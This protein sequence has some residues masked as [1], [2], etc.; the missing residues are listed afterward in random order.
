M[1]VAKLVK[2]PAPK[3]K[4][5]TA[6]KPASKDALP[7]ITIKPRAATDAHDE[8]DFLSPPPPVAEPSSGK[9]TAAPK[10]KEKKPRAKKDGTSSSKKDGT[11]VMSSAKKGKAPAPD[12]PQP[13]VFK[14]R[15]F[16]DDSD[17]NIVPPRPARASYSVV[18]DWF[19]VLTGGTPDATPALTFSRTTTPLRNLVSCARV[20]TTRPPLARPR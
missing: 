19:H 5:K 2:K 1:C 14:S 12:E 8:L 15:E 16:I 7:K 3:P 10:E 17:E 11:M 4:T 20:T 13:P 6:A 9:K 18:G